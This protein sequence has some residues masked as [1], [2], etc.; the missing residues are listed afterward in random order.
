M[1]KM[2]EV[3]YHTGT[4]RHP[5]THI[6]L[7]CTEQLVKQQLA[8]D[9]SVLRNFI[10]GRDGIFPKS[11]DPGISHIILSRDF[12][13]MVWD[14]SGFAFLMQLRYFLQLVGLL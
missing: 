3:E 6:P 4:F 1:K 2:N 9:P 10:P 11:R 13:E 5:C 7:H 8:A 14:F 12:L